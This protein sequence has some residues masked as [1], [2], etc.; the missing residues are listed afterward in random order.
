MGSVSRMYRLSGN[1][2]FV[3]AKVGLGMTRLTGTNSSS[4]DNYMLGV[5]V[6]LNAVTLTANLQQS[7]MSGLVNTPDLN[8]TRNGYSLQAQYNLSKQTY[9]ILGY[10]NWL[11]INKA[12]AKVYDQHSNNTSLLMVKDF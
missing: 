10:N 4:W 5:S 9:F 1:Y 12:T 3:S 7:R 2:D 6:P 8:T 11:G